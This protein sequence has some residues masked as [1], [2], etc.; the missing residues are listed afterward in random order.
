MMGRLWRV[1]R[2]LVAAELVASGL[3]WALV[4]TPESNV[5]MLSLSVLLV[6]GLFAVG[7]VALDGAIRLWHD[8]SAWPSPLTGWLLPAV[9]LMPALALATVVWSVADWV[10]GRVDGARGA[11]TAELIARFG[12]A[13]P[14]VLFRSVAWAMTA[15]QWVVAPVAALGVF[16]SLTRRAEGLPVESWIRQGTNWRTLATTAAATGGFAWLWTSLSAWRPAG[17]PPSWV[18]IVFVGA[19]LAVAAVALAVGTALVVREAT[20]ATR[21]S[22]ET[23]P[24]L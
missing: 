4:S 14:E 1:T 21:A 5:L 24:P 11:I 18:Q 16:S 17:L 15:L 10:G 13:D 8:R 2:W 7:G 9:R 12:W 6:A 22:V 20:A 19:K 23:P 3:Y